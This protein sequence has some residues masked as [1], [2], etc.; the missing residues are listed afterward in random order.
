MDNLPRF[1]FY[2]SGIF[3]IS[4]AFTLFTSELLFK[5]NDP[6][7][8]G[9]AWLIG[10]G[11]VYMNI[12]FVTSRRFMRREDGPS[13]VPIIFGTLVAIMPLVWI[14][15]YNSPLDT[16][17]RIIFAVVVAIACGLGSHFGHKAGLKA[18]VVFKQKLEEYLKKTG[19]VPEDLQRPHD[20]LNKN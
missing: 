2:T 17:N 15:V 5:I 9:T 13:P 12:V 20:N 16:Q 19:Q 8:V 1:A 6:S 3:L 10:F 14:F 7:W 4:A 11:V 18:Q